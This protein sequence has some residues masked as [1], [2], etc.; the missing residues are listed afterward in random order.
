MSARRHSE[1]EIAEAVRDYQLGESAD[2]IAVSLGCSHQT[3]IGWVREA[4]VRVR[5]KGPGRAYL[6][7]RA[8]R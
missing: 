3:V 2:D 7:R 8:E 5:G 6:A 4:G 1:D